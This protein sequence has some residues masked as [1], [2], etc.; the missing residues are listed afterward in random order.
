MELLAPA[1][2]AT[3]TESVASRSPRAD[4]RQFDSGSAYELRANRENGPDKGSNEMM[5]PL[6]PASRRLAGYCPALA[7]IKDDTYFMRCE[8][9]YKIAPPIGLRIIVSHL[10]IGLISAPNKNP[11]RRTNI[12]AVGASGHDR[13]RSSG[14]ALL[15]TSSCG[16]VYSRRPD[17]GGTTTMAW[18]PEIA[19]TVTQL[20]K[21]GGPSSPRVRRASILPGL[22][23]REFVGPENYEWQRAR[24]DGAR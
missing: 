20:G 23:A 5:G 8:C 17:L 10:L 11:P 9:G 24:C 12:G 18:P 22:W 3:F 6:K 13:P 16:W 1:L 4:R 19:L 15:L 2:L 7:R 14:D 21:H